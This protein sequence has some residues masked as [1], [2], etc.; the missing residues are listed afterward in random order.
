MC[1]LNLTIHSGILI[2]ICYYCVMALTLGLVLDI[3][4]ILYS[5]YNACMQRE[6]CCAYFMLIY[7]FRP[8]LIRISMQGVKMKHRHR[9]S[10]VQSK[11]K[12]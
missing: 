12:A 8:I 1:K 7:Y 6:G 3:V 5:I 9:R 11:Q 10:K 4:H 2:Q